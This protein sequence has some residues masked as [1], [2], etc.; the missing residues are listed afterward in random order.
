VIEEAA[1]TWSFVMY[2]L[3]MPFKEPVTVLPKKAF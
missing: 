3:G 2:N 1:D